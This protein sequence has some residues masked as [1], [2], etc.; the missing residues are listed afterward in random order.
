MRMFREFD[1]LCGNVQIGEIIGVFTCVCLFVC[2]GGASG[3]AFARKIFANN[4]ST[5]LHFRSQFSCFAK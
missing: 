3:H 2:L 5:H 4:L 1:Y